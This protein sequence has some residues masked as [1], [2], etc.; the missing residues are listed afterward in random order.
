MPGAP[1]KIRA[2]H[3]AADLIDLHLAA[4]REFGDNLLDQAPTGVYPDPHLS[5]RSPVV[6]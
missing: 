4:T 5:R 3:N 2:E 6:R 1:L